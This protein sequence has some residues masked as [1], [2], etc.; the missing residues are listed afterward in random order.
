MK[1]ELKILD[2]RITS[3][4]YATK[5]SAAVDLRACSSSKGGK[6]EGKIILYPGEK[7]TVGTGIAIH[8][9]AMEDG[10]SNICEGDDRMSLAAI[11]LP[12]SSVGKAGL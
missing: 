5:G 6:I 10:G 4:E 9:G 8:L 2:D 11:V 12:R 1:T 7:I 3:L